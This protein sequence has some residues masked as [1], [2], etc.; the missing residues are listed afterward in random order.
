MGALQRRCIEFAS[1]V[2]VLGRYSNTD[3]VWHV[4][5][6]FSLVREVIGCPIDPSHRYASNRRD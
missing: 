4:Y 3:I 6:T 2:E 1:G 5:D